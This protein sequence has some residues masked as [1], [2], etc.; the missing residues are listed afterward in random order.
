MNIYLCSTVRNLLFA[1][2]KAIGESD[3][4][5]LILMVVDQQN[6]DTS[7]YDLSALPKH[8]K[9][10]F[11]SRKSIR[12]KLD[13]H[14]FGKILRLLATLNVKTFSS[15]RQY[16][17]VYLF[18]R[19]LGGSGIEVG[20]VEKLFL[21]NDRNRLARLLRL[22]F[23]EYSIIEDGLANYYGNRLKRFESLWRRLSN[24]P[25][26][27]RFL[28]DDE[29]CK[30]I[31][32]LAPELAPVEIQYKVRPIAF[33]D[34]KNIL[35][36]CY[37]FFKFEPGSDYDHDSSWILATQ[38]VSIAGLSE[39]GFDIVIYRKI[40]EYLKQAGIHVVI[41][42]H[43]RENPDRYRV[44]FPDYQILESKVP[45]EIMILGSSSKRSIV[46]IYSTAGMGFERYC[47]RITLIRDEESEFMCDTFT[48]WEKD[49]S[50][51]ET[52]ISTQLEE[53]LVQ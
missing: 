22:A 27:K 46:S 48:S 50:L 49:E 28:G 5:C 15:L 43:P 17:G 29:R 33:I 25:H 45:L 20:K 2:L 6:I 19:M 41:K 47:R 16:T 30:E 26:K 23:T 14:A 1:I 8:I 38:P 10:Q 11:I 21:F 35:D 32:L 13:S 18:N 44:E 9:I 31:F 39:S 24:H 12:S 34:Q 37:G 3:N 4:K 51:L 52:R 36:F 40:L 7:D 53:M 42:V